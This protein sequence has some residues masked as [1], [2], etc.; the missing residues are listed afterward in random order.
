[1]FFDETSR[2]NVQTKLPV[3]VHAIIFAE[4]HLSQPS[5]VGLTRDRPLSLLPVANRPLLHYLLEWLEA[6]GIQDATLVVPPSSNLQAESQLA[7]YFAKV[8]EGSIKVTLHPLKTQT[9]SA[10]VLAQL[11]SQ[12]QGHV[13]VLG[14]DFLATSPL[15]SLLTRHKLHRPA[16][17]AYF[18]EPSKADVSA[19]DSGEQ[20]PIIGVE[21]TRSQWVFYNQKVEDLTLRQSLLNQFPRVQLHRTL[22][23]SGVYIFSSWVIDL[24][25]AMP[26]IVSIHRDLVPLLIKM[27]SR[28]TLSAWEYL[29]KAIST[30][31]PLTRQYSTLP[32]KSSWHTVGLDSK[33]DSQTSVLVCQMVMQRTGILGRLNS[34]A[35][36]HE[37]NRQFAK[38]YPT[39]ERIPE[40]V[41]KDK[42]SQIGPDSLVGACVKMAERSSIKKSVVGAHCHIGRNVKIANSVLMDYVIV[43]DGV[44]LEGCVI[45]P[46]ATIQERAQL[47]DCE[48]GDSVSIAAE[49]QLKGSSVWE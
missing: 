10:Q 34:L 24:V 21:P 31:E 20:P 37:L 42:S 4:E 40:S 46:R 19:K 39:E 35:A 1:M 5:L 32:E 17:T 22:F 38:S 12:I 25:V 49:A 3:A 16:L 7:Q 15:A 14:G 48:I 9:G 6:G 13:L 36:Y 28:P 26:S 29:N 44:K 33:S 47:K 45:G 2:S 11:K 23:D 30:Y 43:E 27:Q 18:Y 8:Y 41:E